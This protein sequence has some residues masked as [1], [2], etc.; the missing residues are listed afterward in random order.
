MN[1]IFKLSILK[2]GFISVFM[3]IWEEKKL[4]HFWLIFY[5]QRQ[6]KVNMKKFNKCNFWTLPPKI[7][8]NTKFHENLGIIFFWLILEWLL[9]N[10]KTSKTSK[11]S[12][13]KYNFQAHH[14]K[15]RL[16]TN[17]HKSLRKKIGS[18]L[19][20]FQLIV[21]KMNMKIQ[22]HR[23]TSITLNSPPQN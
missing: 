23:K 10:W 11:I 20:D 5:F 21:A 6:I 3:Q 16:Y 14:P 17:F 4:T 7:R 12:E 18:F 9:N 22:K 19:T 8:L 15:I 1:V 13:S 2:L